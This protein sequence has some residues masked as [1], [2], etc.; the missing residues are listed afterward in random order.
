[1]IVIWRSSKIWMNLQGTLVPKHRLNIL[2]GI[3]LQPLKLRGAAAGA[4]RLF[5]RPW[6]LAGPE[7]LVACHESPVLIY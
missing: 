1:M 5:A 4:F 2:R 6:A 7:T 3:L